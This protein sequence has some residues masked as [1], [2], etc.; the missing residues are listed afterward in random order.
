M[1][2]RYDIGRR[3]TVKPVKS[4]HDLRDAVLEPYTGKIGVIANYYHIQPTGREVFYLYVVRIKDEEKDIVLYEDE[5]QP[6]LE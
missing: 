4:Q 2:A 1:A 3:V 6:V 5:L